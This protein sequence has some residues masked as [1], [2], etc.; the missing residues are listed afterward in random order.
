MEFFTT[1]VVIIQLQSIK[2][3]NLDLPESMC[4]SPNCF[5]DTDKDA[6]AF[7]T[8]FDL[9][10]MSNFIPASSY[11]RSG[12]QLVDL[13]NQWSEDEDYLHMVMSI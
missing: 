1:L 7:I 6:K 4:G 10:F 5:T 12:P 11:I 8:V 9:N 3:I 13:S 2:T